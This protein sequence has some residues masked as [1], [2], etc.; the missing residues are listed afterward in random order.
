VS[1]RVLVVLVV[2]MIVVVA[3]L[4]ALYV[5]GNLGNRAIP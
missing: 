3:G 1:R 5:T 2:V 4:V